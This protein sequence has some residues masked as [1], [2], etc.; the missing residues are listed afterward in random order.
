MQS[1]K[2][3]L[4]RFFVAR[5]VKVHK[6]KIVTWLQNQKKQ[7]GTKVLQTLYSIISR[8]R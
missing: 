5:L 7:N 8:K 2:G 6:N 1:P 4:L 3:Q